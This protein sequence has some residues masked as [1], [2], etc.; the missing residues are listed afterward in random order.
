MHEG[1]HAATKQ[2]EPEQQQQQQQPQDQGNRG[3]GAANQ[4]QVQRLQQLQQLAASFGNG[5][6]PEAVKKALIQLE[7]AAAEAVADGNAMKRQRM[8]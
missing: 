3:S 7:A 4:L 6:L 8:C 5:E 2:L 1:G